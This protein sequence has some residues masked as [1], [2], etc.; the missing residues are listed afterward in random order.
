[1]EN[2][3]SDQKGGVLVEP[4][5]FSKTKVEQ[6]KREFF[7]TEFSEKRFPISMFSIKDVLIKYGLMEASFKHFK[8]T[9]LKNESLNQQCEETLS[10]AEKK[11]EEL[12]ALLENCGKSICSK[13]NPH[14]NSD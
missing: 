2:S 3:D 14:V 11:M 6:P 4:V 8:R 10:E 7:S 1:M 5:L 13:V 9:V 12:R